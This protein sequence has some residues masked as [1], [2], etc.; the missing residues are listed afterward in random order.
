MKNPI[1]DLDDL[2]EERGFANGAA[3]TRWLAGKRKM[4]IAK[5]ADGEPVAARLNHGRWIADCPYCSGAELVSRKGHAFFCLSCGMKGNN[6]R[7]LPVAFP[8][9]VAEIETK[10]ARVAEEYQNWDAER[11][12]E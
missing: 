8:D 12:L 3:Y 1:I 11:G 10:L 9:N 7:P 5:D 6:G 2:A 4:K